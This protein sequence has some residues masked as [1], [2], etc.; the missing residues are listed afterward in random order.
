[1]IISVVIPVYNAEKYI[2]RCLDSILGQNIDGLEIICVDDGS[3]DNSLE[4][5]EYYSKKN[6]EVIVLSQKNQFAGIARNNGLKKA[7]G[8]YIHFM[9]ADDYLQ[10]NVYGK[11]IDF[12]VKNN[13]DVIKFRS[14]AFDE[15]DE[16]ETSENSHYYDNPNW[17]NVFDKVISVRNH[18]F[19]L[20]ECANC[21][22][23]SGVYKRDFLEKNNIRFNGLRCVNDRSFYIQ[24]IISA[25]RIMYIDL[26][27]VRHQIANKDSLVGVRGDNFECHFKSYYEIEHLTRDII[28]E[29]RKR[30][31]TSEMNDIL[32]WYTKMSL[33]QKETIKY[34]IYRFFSS[35]D[36]SVINKNEE[37]SKCFVEINEL[38][39]EFGRVSIVPIEDI[40]MLV[41]SYEYLYVYGAGVMGKRIIKYLSKQGITPQN[42]V[43]SDSQAEEVIDNIEVKRIGDVIFPGD[44]D[45]IGFIIAAKGIYH[46]QMM[47]S[48]NRY[49][50]ENVLSV[51]D[52]DFENKLLHLVEAE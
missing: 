36:W 25:Q 13:T 46:I 5:L 38:L 27:V 2:R 19:E 50:I 3:S 39:K 16:C 14:V 32:F 35:V 45:K 23:W 24:T 43:V 17:G 26:C 44:V 40:I 1:M 47:R 20:I 29:L 9:D 10:P 51:S 52:E 12:A 22:P 49:G 30:I 11:I 37:M 7:S 15:K 48:L 41:N 34:E 42:I 33:A 4:I 28:P 31:M 21:T 18:S 8:K 6:E